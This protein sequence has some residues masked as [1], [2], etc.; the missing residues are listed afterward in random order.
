[1]SNRSVI[2]NEITIDVLCHLHKTATAHD[3]VSEL[4]RKAINY[5]ENTTL[6]FSHRTYLQIAGLAISDY[7]TYCK[8]NH[9]STIH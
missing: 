4:E 8:V 2:I 1:M 7:L 6:Y 3:S 9:Q 5:L